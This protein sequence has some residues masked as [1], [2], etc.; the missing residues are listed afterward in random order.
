MQVVFEPAFDHETTRVALESLSLRRLR[1]ADFNSS[2]STDL[3]LLQPRGCPQPKK[4]A[5]AV[6]R[7]VAAYSANHV[8][9][10]VGYHAEL[11]AKAAC[12]QIGGRVMPPLRTV[13]P[14]SAF[15]DGCVLDFGFVTPEGRFEIEVKNQLTEPSHA[16]IWRKMDAVRAA[17][18]TFVVIMR[19]GGRA[20]TKRLREEGVGVVEFD[21]YL[22]PPAL[23]PLAEELSERLGLPARVVSEPTTEFVRRV[24]VALA[25]AAFGSRPPHQARAA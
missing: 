7:L 14:E 1:G 15:V 12:A 3:V 18:R 23:Q 11:L 20:F 8:A 10:G 13:R 25:T 4:D 22:F 21:D 5:A 17:G 24:G 2:V 6:A 19:H 9:R 16:A